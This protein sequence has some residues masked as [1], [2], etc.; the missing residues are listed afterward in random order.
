MSLYVN[1][2]QADGELACEHS[3]LPKAYTQMIMSE[4]NG[5]TITWIGCYRYTQALFMVTLQLI[6]C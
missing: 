5:I 6:E 3:N 1:S 4:I 2:Y